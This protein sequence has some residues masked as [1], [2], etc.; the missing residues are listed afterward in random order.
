MKTLIQRVLKA[1]V[2]VDGQTIG[3]IG[4]GILI[5]LGITNGDSEKQ[6]DFLSNK[7]ANL[8]IFKGSGTSEFDES[9]LEQKKE[10]L[11]V[12]QFTLYGSCNKGRRPDFNDAARPEVAEPIYEMFV[13]KIEALGI[14]TARGKFGADMQVELVNDGPVTFLI[15]N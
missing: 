3:E 6:A 5:L 7:I 2:K 10:I 15:E 11:V 8:R 14:Q 13:K 1:S 4:P 12:S 9:V